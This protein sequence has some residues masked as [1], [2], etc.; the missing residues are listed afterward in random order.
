MLVRQSGM[1]GHG[2]SSWSKW[3]QLGAAG[4]LSKMASSGLF[5]CLHT[6]FKLLQISFWLYSSYSSLSSSSSPPLLPLL[7]PPLPPHFLLLIFFILLL[8][9]LTSFTSSN[10]F[11]LL[12]CLLFFLLPHPP[13]PSPCIPLP[14]LPP[15]TSFLYSS[16]FLLLIPLLLAL[17]SPTL[18]FDLFIP[19]WP[20]GFIMLRGELTFQS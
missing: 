11:F 9:F 17:S 3:G 5:D 8:L 20:Q 10:Y 1:S 13:L 16:D 6:F 12:L 15:P 18:W 14:Q 2:S 7:S 4:G 19:G